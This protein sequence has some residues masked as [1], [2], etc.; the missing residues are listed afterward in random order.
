MVL[1]HF[2]KLQ[3][4][5]VRG[6]LHCI[7]C[8]IFK[9]LRRLGGF[10]PKL[11]CEYKLLKKLKNIIKWILT[12]FVYLSRGLFRTDSLY[13]VN[14]STNILFT[15]IGEKELTCCSEWEIIQCLC[16]IMSDLNF[17]VGFLWF[18]LFHNKFHAFFNSKKFFH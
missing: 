1:V 14:T 4:I 6:S 2:A 17:T 12:S 15:T 18:S 16:G 5:T 11:W 9:L 10:N 13:R 7:Y 3:A 8:E